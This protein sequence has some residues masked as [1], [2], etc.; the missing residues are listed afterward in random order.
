MAFCASSNMDY[1]YSIYHSLPHGISS[2]VNIALSYWTWGR[3][4]TTKSLWPWSG[5]ND[6]GAVSIMK[7]RDV[8]FVK[9]HQ[10]FMACALYKLSVPFIIRNRKARMKAFQQCWIYRCN[11]LKR[12]YN[13]HFGVSTTNLCKHIDCFKMI[14]IGLL[15]AR[16]T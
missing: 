2:H 1:C 5:Y 12:A 11:S 3:R 8:S 10:I 14:W 6:D 15:I 7:T 9:S 13:Q 16:I 4:I